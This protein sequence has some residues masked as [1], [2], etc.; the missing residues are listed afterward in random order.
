MSQIE[1]I[2]IT[3]RDEW[4]RLRQRDCTASDIPAICG[5]GMYG[6]A[7]S[8]WAHKRGLVPPQADNDALRRGRWGEAAVFEALADEHPD[9]E[10]RRAKVYLRDPALRL[11]A[12]PDGVAIV[13]G[14]EGVVV[15]QTKI[16]AAPVF[17]RDWLLDA[18]DDV[19]HGEIIAPVG[20]ALQTLT[21]CML[22]GASCGVL[23]A[24]VVDTFRWTL[25]L[26]WIDRHPMAERSIR[27]KVAEF[28]TRYL[29]PGVQP[30]IEPERD[31]DLVRSLFPADDG[32]TVDLSG[33]N[34]LPD[35]LERREALK[36]EIKGATAEL[37]EI[38]TEIKGALGAAARATLPGW[39]I[40][41]PTR[42]RK[43]YVVQPTTYRQLTVKRVPF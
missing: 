13:P 19:A 23:A 11:G 36:A 30:P 39:D 14:R 38:E 10:L 33:S 40:R 20:Y 4:L 29:D 43:G 7:A 31:G 42:E 22:A 34:M 21:E 26:C 41:L 24:L 12:T 27:E 1:R 18:S 35:R 28:W 5:V 25:R 17:R 2:P 3:D 9:W 8:V 16:V 15:V 32:T 6:S 37:A